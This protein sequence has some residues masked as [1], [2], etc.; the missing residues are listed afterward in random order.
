MDNTIILG[1]VMFTL[2]VL[3][4]VMVILVARQWL[5]SSGAVTIGINGDPG[6][7][8]TVEAGGKLLNTLAAN[9]IFLAS[10]CGWWRYLRAMPLPSHVGRR[11]HLV[12]RG[13]ALHPR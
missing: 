11:Q 6:K 1:V 13:R 5:V 3:F 9:G 8:V 4:L 10:A 12:H 2:T 7:A